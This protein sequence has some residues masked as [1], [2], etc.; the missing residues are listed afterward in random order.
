MIKKEYSITGRNELKIRFD[1]RRS[2]SYAKPVPIFIFIHGFKGYKDWGF[3]P[4]LAEQTAMSNA[5]S[6][7]PDLSENGIINTN[8]PKFDAEIFAGQTISGHLAD[9]EMLI[10]ELI[11]NPNKYELDEM[12]N[13]EII[14]G[15][16]SLGGALSAMIAH[17]FSEI[18]KVFL[19]ASIANINRNTERQLDVWKK[20]G[21]TALKIVSTGQ[22]L[23]LN[24]SYAKD[25]ENFSDEQIAENLSKFE[26]DA[27]IIH[28]EEDLIVKPEESQK[29]NKYAKNGKLVLIKK[30]NHTFFAN[31]IMNKPS[32]AIK[33]VVNELNIFMVR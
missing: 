17:K 15:G 23:K 10:N 21:F 29:L 11:D 4:Y 13:G 6:I 22:I 30:A 20:K 16:H 27:L 1:I 31:H 7:T 32:D 26:G 14:L 3:I 12:W 33:E 28:P 19:L 24:Y 9:I 2:E 5:I 18:K 8:P 25:K